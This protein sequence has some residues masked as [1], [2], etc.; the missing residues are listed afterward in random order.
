MPNE[1]DNISDIYASNDKLAKKGLKEIEDEIK[2]KISKDDT[3]IYWKHIELSNKLKGNPKLH[4]IYK[5]Y[6]EKFLRFCKF[7]NLFKGNKLLRKRYRDLLIKHIEKTKKRIEEIRKVKIAGEIANNITKR[8]TEK[9]LTITR[10]FS[11]R[12]NEQNLEWWDEF[13]PEWEELAITATMNKKG[14]DED[15]IKENDSKTREA[16]EDNNWYVVT[17]TP[18]TSTDTQNPK[19]VDS[20]TYFKLWI[21]NDTRKTC[22]WF[23]QREIF[24]QQLKKQSY[25][26]EEID[27]KFQ[28]WNAERLSNISKLFNFEYIATFTHDQG[29][30]IKNLTNQAVSNHESFVSILWLM[31]NNEQGQNN[32]K[33]I[34]DEF[35]QYTKWELIWEFL[36]NI[37]SIPYWLLMLQILITSFADWNNAFDLEHV[38]WEWDADTL[39]FLSN[40]I[41]DPTFKNEPRYQEYASTINKI[42]EEHKDVDYKN[43]E[44]KFKT[45]TEDQKLLEEYWSNPEAF[46]KK[47]TIEWRREFEWI[48][49]A[50]LVEWWW[51]YKSWEQNFINKNSQYLDSQISELFELPTW[52]NLSEKNKD[53]IEE[54]RSRIR[55]LLP[56]EDLNRIYDDFSKNPEVQERFKK[57]LEKNNLPAIDLNDYSIK[58]AIL[59]GNFEG[60][61]YEEALKD[62][63]NGIWSMFWNEI[64]WLT[65]KALQYLKTESWW[66]ALNIRNEVLKHLLPWISIRHEKE[67]NW[68]FYFRDENNLD[69]L[70]QFDPKTWE[71]A[72]HDNISNETDWVVDLWW[73]S[74]SPLLTIKW[75]EWIINSLQ[76]WELL[77]N[78]KA[79]NF[80]ELQKNLLNSI[81]SKITVDWVS[82]I[83][84]VN[85]KNIQLRNEKNTCKNELVWDFK[86]L[87]W[88]EASK[89]TKEE[90]INYT[91]FNSLANT[92]KKI[93]STPSIDNHQLITMRNFF[94]KVC[95][96]VNA[97]NPVKADI[98]Q[99]IQNNE[100][101]KKNEQETD[102]NLWNWKADFIKKLIDPQTKTFN[103]DL[104][105]QLLNDPEFQTELNRGNFA[106]LLRVID[107]WKELYDLEIQKNKDINNL[108]SDIKKELWDA[109]NDD[110]LYS[111]INN[112]EENELLS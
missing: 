48:T 51:D 64:M 69:T 97:W 66:T 16:Q 67:N 56:S 55:K 19:R 65:N 93:D 10:V 87:L 26:A 49:A 68:I 3:Y 96:S 62:C 38:T 82:D 7:L 17:E 1:F 94:Y 77:P 100:N 107:K 27:K 109:Y 90:W 31:N 57:F 112:L 84:E 99:W 60:N 47:Q 80:E 92:F 104:M 42:L 103:I 58:A 28:Q 45:L 108:Y 33:A 18:W 74:T 14:N 23:S 12:K 54:K 79:N 76:V 35:S 88:V 63:Y 52:E 20:N 102:E 29:L 106:N 46:W 9:A 41:N 13:D 75:Y 89:V 53:E 32:E 6:L 4:Y 21:G 71:I 83:G 86:F 85:W 50:Q 24:F 59:N 111:N 70:Y 2:E 34:L 110:M 95:E 36:K 91:L 98:L 81:K 43:K 8:A 25:K 39:V 22:R 44:S 40:L 78:S 101:E 37:D 15:S 73:W 11:K 61:K 30:N 105:E 5:K 72:L